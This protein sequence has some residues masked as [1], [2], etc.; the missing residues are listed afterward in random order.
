M[1]GKHS[2]DSPETGGRMVSPVRKRV[3][4]CQSL[5]EGANIVEYRW[6]AASP[7]S[8]VK[9]PLSMRRILDSAALDQ[10][11]PASRRAAASILAKSAS[12]QS[13]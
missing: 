3:S 8:L 12:R 1:I 11:W 2:E 10:S 5:A 6:R 7:F 4:C 9:P 13:L